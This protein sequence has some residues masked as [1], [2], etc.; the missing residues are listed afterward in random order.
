[1]CVIKSTAIVFE[2]PVG[3]TEPSKPSKIAEIA[4]I[5]DVNAFKNARYS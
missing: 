4:K 3:S 5:N 1:M 2:V